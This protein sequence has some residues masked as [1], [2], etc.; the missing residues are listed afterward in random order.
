M[1]TPLFVSTLIAAA[2]ATVGAWPLVGA[3]GQDSAT[4]RDDGTSVTRPVP[5]ARTAVERLSI[6]QLA[7][8]RVIV[9]YDGREPPKRLFRMIRRGLVAGVIFFGA[10]TGF[11]PPNFATQRAHLRDLIRRMQRARRQ[12]GP[13]ILRRPL[14]MMTDQEGG[15]VRRLG[16][17]PS[18]SE[19]EIGTANN[20]RKLAKQAG[21]GAGQNLATV[22]MN[23]NLAPVMGVIDSGNGFL[24]QFQRSY[25]F[26]RRE[27]GRLGRLFINAQQN[28]G[29]A[30]TA[31]HFPGLGAATRNE[32]TDAG[33]VTLKIPLRR[34]RMKDEFP[35]TQAIA[36]DTKLIMISNARYPALDRKLPA[37]MSPKIIGGELRQRLGYDG[38]TITDALEAGGLKSVG[39]IPRRGVQGARAGADLLLFSKQKLNE[40]I[41]AS[42]AIRRALREGRLNRDAFEASVLR[43]LKLRNELS[44]VPRG[45]LR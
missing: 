29:V 28:R 30:S 22:A 40:G 5:A 17:A 13:K 10:N 9:S 38:V 15:L 11:V 20:G 14:L 42:K 21:N 3:G 27:V 43:V 24:G 1:R 31:K 44:A 25:G 2:L 33:P 8:Q 7:G 6:K 19:R 36:A 41:K 39:S 45:P 12:A 23:V 26:N 4:A 18:N 34:L 35:F 37:S 32:N 16:G